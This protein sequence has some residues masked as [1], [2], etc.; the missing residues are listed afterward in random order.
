AYPLAG[1]SIG[2]GMRGVA[3][4]VALDDE[5]PIAMDL[6]AAMVLNGRLYGG[7]VPLVPD[8]RVDDGALDIV[9]FR[10]GGPLDTTAH[11]ARVLAGLH[12]TDPS[13][14]I[15]RVQRVYID[16]GESPLPVETDGDL[17]G[18]TPLDVRV[19]PGALLALGIQS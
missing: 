12:H 19:L 7:M 11:A 15:R 5:P 16:T 13:V 18:A 4:T 10:G 8:A 2:V 14:L 3:A 17:H 1:I 6:L 9:L